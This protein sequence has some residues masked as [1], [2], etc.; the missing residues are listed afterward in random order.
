MREG[1]HAGGWAP[2]AW[3][4]TGQLEDHPKWEAQTLRHA[5]HEVHGAAMPSKCQS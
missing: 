5:S 3:E 2:A 1:S 4:G